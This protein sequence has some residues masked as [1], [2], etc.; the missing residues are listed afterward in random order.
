MGFPTSLKDIVANVESLFYVEDLSNK[1]GF[2]QSINPLVKMTVTILLIIASL[3]IQELH[4]LLLFCVIPVILAVTSRI[5]FRNFITRTIFIPCF[6]M[7]VSLPTLFLTEGRIFFSANLHLFTFSITFE[8]LTRFLMFASRVWFCVACLIVFTLSTGFDTI[9]QLLAMLK[10]PAVIIQMFSLT[11][12]YLFVSIHEL[13]KVLIAKEARTYINPRN[14]NLQNLKQS[15]AIIAN[16]FIRTYDRAERV[17]MAMKV[18]GFNIN[19]NKPQT[20]LYLS[21]R[22]VAF[23]TTT[24][25][26]VCLF[27]IF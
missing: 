3:F 26:I 5:P 1:R 18:R 7:V 25:T 24:A 27:T 21:A 11:Y 2:L 4:Y 16:L 17:Y 19:S 6:A 12:R 15:G 14:I 8:G 13:Q 22:D 9:L 23:I 10:V 20:T